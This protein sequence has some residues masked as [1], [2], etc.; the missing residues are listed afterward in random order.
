MALNGRQTSFIEEYIRNGENG[1]QA[2]I[3]AGYSARSARVTARR[4]LTNAN[5]IAVLAERRA[6]VR[7]QSRL[8]TDDVM[9]FLEDVVSGRSVE[10]V[11]TSSGETV[12]IPVKMS[13]RLKAA[14][15]LAKAMGMFT[16]RHIVDVKPIV[17]MGEYDDD[18][19]I[20]K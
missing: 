6:E 17:V 3:R 20:M 7:E 18:D 14:E 8:T 9:K 10:T 11:V 1:A 15:N 13:N 4:L 19:P 5:I 16:E 2:A 12:E